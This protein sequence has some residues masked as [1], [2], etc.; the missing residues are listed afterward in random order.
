MAFYYVKNGGTATGDAGRYTTQQTGSFADLGAANYYDNV[1]AARLATTAPVGGD[2]V[3]VSD[4]SSYSQTGTDTYP[5]GANTPVY[6]VSVDDANMDQAKVAT[7]AQESGTSGGDI[8]YGTSGGQK[9]TLWGMYLSTQD[10]IGAASHPTNT[11]LIKCTMRSNGIWDKPI[12]LNHAGASAEL[13]GCTVRHD[14]SAFGAPLYVSRSGT[15]YWRG[16]LLDSDQAEITYLFREGFT[17]GCSL[18]EIE[19]VDLS[20]IGGTGSYLLGAVGS[21]DG[22]DD[23]FLIKISKCAISSSVGFIEET[24]A[25][26]HMRMEV[27]QCG[28]SSASEYQ[29]FVAHGGSTVEDE[30]SISRDNSTAFFETSQKVSYKAISGAEVSVLDPFYFEVT[31]QVAELSGASSDTVRIFLMSSDSGLTDQ[32]VWATL[33]YPDG[34]TTHI[35]SEVSTAN[36]DPLATGTAL[37]ANSDAWTGRTTE[38]R[39]QIDLDTSAD[40]GADCVPVVRVFIGKPSTTVYFDTTIDVVA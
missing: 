27:T 23:G 7:S 22:L 25:G 36:S 31:A 19:G 40:V 4:A 18:V 16:G 38:T 14:G 24:L 32:D 29:Y 20:I 2:Y 1:E 6:I 21:S 26:Q 33:T 35:Y 13:I 34:T 28:F 39:Y 17:D 3:C 8:R 37:T 12:Y 11:R 10:F 9:L 15:L 30:T 5:G